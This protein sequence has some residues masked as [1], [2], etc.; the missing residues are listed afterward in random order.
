[1][2]Q[3]RQKRKLRSPQKTSEKN[4]KFLNIRIRVGG[5]GRG[6]SPRNLSPMQTAMTLA[7]S[8]WHNCFRAPDAIKG[9]QLPGEDWAVTTVNLVS[10]ALAQQQLHPSQPRP[11]GEHLCT[12][13]W[14]SRLGC[15][16]WAKRILGS[17]QWLLLPITECTQRSTS[18][19]S[20]KPLLLRLK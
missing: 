9:L 20:G 17:D 19:Y 4:F 15:P 12:C 14:S 11:Q 1:M 5:G 7:E 3:W 8:I 10:L 18:P 6:G 16:G 13:S 2:N